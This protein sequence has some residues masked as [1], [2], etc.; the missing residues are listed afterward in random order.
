VA[1][2]RLRAVPV[3]AAATALHHAEPP[4]VGPGALLR[5]P[6]PAGPARALAHVSIKLMLPAAAVLRAAPQKQH[7]SRPRPPPRRLFIPP[8]EPRPEQPAALRLRSARPWG[9]PHPA[10]TAE[11]GAPSSRGLGMD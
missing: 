6:V 1:G 8:R 10:P 2:V 7:R 3:G 5:V 4:A 11:R 9:T